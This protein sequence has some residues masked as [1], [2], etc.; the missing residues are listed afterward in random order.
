MGCERKRERRGER[1]NACLFADKLLGCCFVSLERVKYSVEPSAG[2]WTPVDQEIET[3]NG[4]T[5]GA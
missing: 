4:I 5:I 1:P 3:R 2:V